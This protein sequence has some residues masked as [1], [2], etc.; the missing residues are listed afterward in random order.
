MGGKCGKNKK[1]YTYKTVV[2]VN[3]GKEVRGV[4]G[5][6]CNTPPP[7]IDVKLK[8][9]DRVLS[10]MFLRGR[11]DRGSPS[12]SRWKTRIITY[13]KFRSTVPAGRPAPRLSTGRAAFSELLAA[14]N[15]SGRARKTLVASFIGIE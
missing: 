1:Y 9:E 14:L 13:S 2:V 6:G 5:G 7:L 4:R 11:E 3:A 15:D 8:G 12:T 10:L